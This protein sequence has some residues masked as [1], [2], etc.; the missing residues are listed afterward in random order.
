MAIIRHILRDPGGLFGLIILFILL[1]AAI[2]GGFLV[3][4]PE[5]AYETV[6]WDASLPPSLDHWFGTDALGRDVFSRVVL[7]A[8]LILKICI[9]TTAGAA[10]IGVPLGLIAGYSN[11]VIRSTILRVT[12]VFLALPQLVLALAFAAVLAP[13]IETAMIALTLSY[14]PMFTRVVYGET[15]RIR[16]LPFI[17]ALEAFGA[18]RFRIIWFHV[19]PN[20]APVIIVRATIGFGV[21]ILA[22]S[23]LGFMGLG[24]TP[25]QPEWGLMV[26]ESRGDLPF[27]WWQAT[28]PGLAIFFTVIA[29][30]FVGDAARDAIDPTLRRGDRRG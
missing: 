20:V 4:H 22:A 13:S 26:S 5:A 3:P 28:F 24:A 9:V 11:S 16:T 17:D 1:F 2:F 19:L 25:P 15:R 27:G 18:S 12:D 23:A 30:N 21:S 7:G 8:G 14:W 29:F 10:L 6:I